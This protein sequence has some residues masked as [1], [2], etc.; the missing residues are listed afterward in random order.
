[1]KLWLIGGAVA[2][3]G[4][5]VLVATRDSRAATTDTPNE[6][7]YTVVRGELP[8]TLTENGTLV[9]KES[10]Q[11]AMQA[12]R[13]GKIAWLIDAGKEVAE[14]DVLCRIDPTELQS[15]IQQAELDITQSEADLK[16]AQNEAELQVTETQA[17]LE[18]AG[19]AL[20]KAEKELKRYTEGDGPQEQRKLLIALKDK[21]TEYGNKKKVFED[22]KTLLEQNYL[23]RSDLEKD[24]IAFERAQVELEG[25]ELEL[26]MFNEYKHPMALSDKQIAVSD[27]KREVDATR[28][29]N[30]GK[31]LQCQ[32]DVTR[33][34]KS[35]LQRK[36]RLR[37]QKEDLE[38]FTL[39]APCA[40]IV[41]HGDPKQPWYRENLKV[42]GDVWEGTTVCTIPDLRVMQVKVQVHEADIN[43]L[44]PALKAT[45]TMESYPGVVL[46]GEVTNIASIANTN[47]E[48]G[49]GGA[50]AVKKFDVEIT[51][52]QRE[53]LKLR[54]GISAKATV[55][56]DHL[57]DVVYV[58]LQSVV[59]EAGTHALF[60]AAD[61]GQSARRVVEVGASN[62]NY[63][64]ITKGVEPGERVLLYNPSLGKQ[65]SGAGKE[66]AGAEG[67][68]DDKAADD[69]A[70]T[71]AVPAAAAATGAATTGA[72][73]K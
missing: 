68:G 73:S 45:I 71:E 65:Q 55:A 2:L 72:A 42:G 59:V 5:G 16:K 18:K 70:K 50:D 43:K 32:V 64:Q 41:L 56:I 58:P 9:A 48:W 40:G 15:S 53:G 46:G 62:D 21:Q 25:A 67:K 49:G 13:G 3:A 11:V 10:K 4:G 8:I 60:V 34:E 44:K 35:L 7:L 19:I 63:V 52:E 14:G 17:N 36:E 26:K 31:L 69:K 23:K 54:P 22:S 47:N 57:A 20:D 66:G 6:G 29:R 1:M 12:S 61:A 39:K 51:I 28:K 30:E 38:R 27:A 37:Q 24:Q 33:C